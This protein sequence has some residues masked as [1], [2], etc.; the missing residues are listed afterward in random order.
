[1]SQEVR[2]HEL[3]FEETSF[4]P[5]QNRTPMRRLVR[6]I[7]DRLDEIWTRLTRPSAGDDALKRHWMNL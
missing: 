3:E 7:Q 4:V 5:A 2:R 6:S 1:M